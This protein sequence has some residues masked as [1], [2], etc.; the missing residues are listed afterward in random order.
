MLRDVGGYLRGGG[1]LVAGEVDG[2][3]AVPIPMAGRH[4][5]ITIRGGEQQILRDER[6]TLALDVTSKQAVTCE[7]LLGID[8]PREV[9]LL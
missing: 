6:A 4:R 1:A 2:G 8:G 5:S 9:N 7:V 3:H